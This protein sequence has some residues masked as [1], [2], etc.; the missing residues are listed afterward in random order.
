MSKTYLK[1]ILSSLVLTFFLTIGFAF[2][3]RGILQDVIP[4]IIYR[5]S[6]KELNILSNYI[7]DMHGNVQQYTYQL[8]SDTGLDALMHE[9]IMDSEEG[10]GA[11]FDLQDNIRINPIYQSVSFYSG[12][13]GQFYSTMTSR[14]GEDLFFKEVLAEPDSVKMLQPVYRTLPQDV[15]YQNV[16]VFSYF[17][18]ETNLYGRI[19]KAITVNIDPTYICDYL[20][21][22]KGNGTK[23][24]IV[25]LQNG[26]V[27]N[28]ATQV[29]ELAEYQDIQK[30]VETGRN[31]GCF[32]KETDNGEYLITY[33]RMVS[34]DWLLVLEE[35][36][37]EL[38]NVTELVRNTLLLV[39]LG[40]IA[41]GVAL[42]A[43]LFYHL[44]RP[45]G[46]LY[47]Q[48][49]GEQGG[50]DKENA[51][52]LYDD[53]EAINHSIQVTQ[54]QL[55]EYLK[56]KNSLGN[57]MREAYIRA[58]LREDMHFIERVSE[59]DQKKMQKFFAQPMELVL[60][61]I[62]HWKQIK[63]SLTANVDACTYALRQCA[64]LIFPST[65]EAPGF[66]LVYLSG[67]QFLLCVFPDRLKQ[68][69][70]TAEEELWK[71]LRGL[72]EKMKWAF[73]EQTGIY[74]TI[75]MGGSSASEEAFAARYN[76][77]QERSAFAIVYERQWVLTRESTVE[78]TESELVY[79][80]DAERRLVQAVS[81]GQKEESVALLDEILKN[82]RQGDWHTFVLYLLQLF[83]AIDRQ[84]AVYYKKKSI[85]IKT[86]V[87]FYSLAGECETLDD[88]REKF[89]DNLEK[90]PTKEEVSDFKANIIVHDVKEYIL[91]HFRE[92]IS[93]KGIS[94]QFNLSQ[95]YL[96]AMFRSA[97]GVSVMEYVNDIRV[98]EAAELLANSRLNISAI[99]EKCGFFNE[100]NFYRQFKQRYGVTPKIYR[101]EKSEEDK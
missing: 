57:L 60:L 4:D 18:Y 49:A 78:R 69:A 23:A 11:M 61:K 55:E 48:V 20:N 13:T 24:Y 41:A 98:K 92:D 15:Y 46:R 51:A 94:A 67:G 28:G 58:L 84:M 29:S 87:S 100:S 73:T 45:W 22:M 66:E 14:S 93:L 63:A 8:A 21:R 32:A 7:E 52:R 53:I 10:Y 85:A 83:L 81:R 96:G 33:Q 25:D 91:A 70:G 72:L 79:D 26:V 101:A 2:S 40:L 5:K 54:N 12:Y 65:G 80:E 56:Y 90:L 99:M 1:M 9:G 3:I 89:M 38:E 95:G 74:V 97:E 30:I 43:V 39:M 6:M 44:Y 34:P 47:Q 76:E 37:T 71:V 59:A 86:P 68:R 88:I 77:A 19:T 36:N 17:Y 16:G 75:A 62:N 82:Y 42:S 64:E 50:N 35:P 31:Q 27:I